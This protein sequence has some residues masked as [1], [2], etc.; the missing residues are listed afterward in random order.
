VPRGAAVTVEQTWRLAQRW[1][2]GRLDYWWTP[3]TPAAIECVFTDVGLI[4]EVWRVT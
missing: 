3:R 2:A 1:Y 4:G